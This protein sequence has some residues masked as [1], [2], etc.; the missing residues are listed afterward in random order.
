MPKVHRIPAAFGCTVL[1]IA[2]CACCA[3]TGC[4]EVDPEEGVA[5]TVNAQTIAEDDVTAYIEGFRSQ[6]TSY[7]TADAWA[8]YLTEAGYTAEG[9][10]TYVIENK[11]VPELLIRQSCAEL[12]ISVS[13]EE[14]DAAIAESHDLYETRYGADSWDSVL[15][16]Y[17]Q[18]EDSWREAEELRLLQEKLSRQVTSYQKASPEQKQDFLDK[19][20]ASYAGRHSLYI[21]F[22]SLDDAWDAYADL[23][24]KKKRVKTK[25]FKRLGHVKDGGWDSLPQDAEKLSNEYLSALYELKAHR[26]AEPLETD[27]G[28]VLILCDRVFKPDKKAAS[29]KRASV[30]KRILA[31]ID[32]DATEDLRDGLFD[33]WLGQITDQSDIKITEMPSGLPYD[34]DLS[35]A[36]TDAND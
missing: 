36:A 7:E 22:D 8:S 15:S 16:A 12:Q 14:L 28:A 1:V 2:A 3:L 13:A 21:E 23:T 35:L 34:S 9:I 26:L 17:G 20:A 30:P 10:R 33:E 24:K 5:A 4:G 6:N 19:N 27:E 11:F 31:Q 18:D 25:R 32:E 29:I